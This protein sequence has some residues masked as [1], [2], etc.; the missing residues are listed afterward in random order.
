MPDRRVAEIETLNAANGS[1]QASAGKAGC[2]AETEEKIM[3]AL[4][5]IEFNGHTYKFR[6]EDCDEAMTKLANRKVFGGNS[7]IF[8]PSLKQYDADTCGKEWAQ[9]KDWEG[10]NAIVSIIE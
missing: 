3:K 6:G 4:Y 10:K 7:I 2:N 1:C 8:D 9:Y 5:K